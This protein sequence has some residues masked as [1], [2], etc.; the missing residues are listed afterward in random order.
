MKINVELLD[1][2]LNKS[3]VADR[4]DLVECSDFI[5]AE[6]VF[7]E[8]LSDLWPSFSQLDDVLYDEHTLLL[9]RKIED[10]Q[11]KLELQA[12]QLV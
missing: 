2:D 7:T 9:Y 8:S 4:H 6:P 5:W 1:K 12:C 3:L 11:A 10:V